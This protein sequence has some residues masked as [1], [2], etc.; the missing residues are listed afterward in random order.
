MNKNTWNC[1]TVGKLFASDKNILSHIT[2]CK[3]VLDW[4]NLNYITAQII[5]IRKEYF[6]QYSFVKIICTHS[7]GII[8][9][10]GLKR[11]DKSLFLLITWNN[12]TAWNIWNH[13][14]ECKLFVLFKNTQN[15]IIM[16]E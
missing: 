15:H 9:Y 12:I 1:T 5:I 7:I 16:I 6:K 11:I 13:I 4:N 10:N 2:V 8:F 14:I 3:I